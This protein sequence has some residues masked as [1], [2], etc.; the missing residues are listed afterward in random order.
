MR[1]IWCSFGI[2]VAPRTACRFF[3]GVYGLLHFLLGEIL[4]LHPLSIGLTT[5]LPMRRWGLWLCTLG[6]VC[7]GSR[8]WRCWHVFA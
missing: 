1:R 7:C 4:P 2:G 8:F 6:A 5:C 3:G